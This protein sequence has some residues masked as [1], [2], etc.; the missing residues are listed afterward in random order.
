[1]AAKPFVEIQ[2]NEFITPNFSARLIRSTSWVISRLPISEFG[3]KRLSLPTTGAP[4]SSANDL[5]RVAIASS[6]WTE[7][8]VN[9]S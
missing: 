7:A 8:Q 4:F 9:L 1:L 2:R 3:L 6:G 5:P